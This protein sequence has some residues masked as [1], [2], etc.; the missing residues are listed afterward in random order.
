MHFKDKE[1]L[2]FGD[3]MLDSYEYGEVNRISPEAPVPVL[4]ITNTENRLGGAAN[5]AANIKSMGGKPHLLGI[6]GKDQNAT[7][8]K[9]ILK[10][11][12]IPFT[13]LESSNF[14]TITKKRMVARNQHLLRIDNEKELIKADFNKLS[15]MFQN[16]ISKSDIVIISDY[17]KGINQDIQE[18]ISLCRTDNKK[19]I[20]DPKLRFL[21]NYANADF[22]TPNETEMQ[23]FIGYWNS[24]QELAEKVKFKMIENNISNILLTRSEKGL[25][26]FTNNK[27]NF[28]IVS[29]KPKKVDVYD[30]SGAGDSVVAITSLL[31]V[32][33]YNLSENLP[34]INTVGG[35]SVSRFGTYTVKAE[36][37]WK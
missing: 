16:R 35:I 6:I 4:K 36:E 5:V 1:I 33:D 26:L 28:K 24:E 22:L 8:L 34:L 10:K 31:I 27:N 32:N 2:V 21:E 30:V 25:T 7:I 3:I 13:L 14:E 23:S 37:I 9:L 17:N 15:V 29:D 11:Q 12:G 20:I 18:F 19:V